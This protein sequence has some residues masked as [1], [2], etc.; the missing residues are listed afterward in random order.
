[1]A[2]T[3]TGDLIISLMGTPA[4]VGLARTLVDA[5]IRKWDYFHI[6]DNALLIVSELV[7][8]AARQTP[9]E[10]IRLQCSRD[11]YGVTIAVWD[12]AYE[13]PRAKPMRELTL[14]D[15]DLSEAA[16]DDN[17]GWGLHIVQV[18]SAKCGVIADPGGGK[19][20]WSRCAT[21]RS[22]ISPAQP[23]GT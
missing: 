3:V 10:E 1:M 12:G 23:G 17:G 9:R 15:L 13:L 14:D 20:V 18:L 21:R 4:S 5:R 16:F 11:S 7:T 2:M 6:L 22:D 19:W 8:N